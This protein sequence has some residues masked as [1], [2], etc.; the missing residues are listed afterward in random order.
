MFMARRTIAVRDAT[1]EDAQALLDIWTDF[2]TGPE[3]RLGCDVEE[4]EHSVLRLETEPAERLLVAVV[5]EQPVGV[6]HLRR[7]PISPIHGE[8]AIHVGYL[9]VLSSF[10]RRGIGKTLLEAASDWADDKDTQ[11]IVAVAGAN[12]R[13]ANRFLARLGMS[14]VAVVRATTVAA[15]RSKLAVV[16]R[17][18][19]TTSVIAARRLRRRGMAT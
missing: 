7:A 4:V 8:D 14:Q 13:D 6:A 1:P 9:H 15:L 18:R 12:A 10:R 2:A 17:K 11:H 5:E 16:P 3:A 19:V